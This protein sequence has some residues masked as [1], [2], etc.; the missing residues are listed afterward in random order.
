MTDQLPH[1]DYVAQ[2]ALDGRMM[3]GAAGCVF[4]FGRMEHGVLVTE[5]GWE[6]NADGARSLT[7]FAQKSVARGRRPRDR[8]PWR[9]P[10]GR[11]SEETFKRIGERNP[12]LPFVMICPRGHR[13]LIDL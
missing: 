10:P 2:I 3:C 12:L 4:W 5:D 1:Y 6:T 8:R 11:P 13:N 7:S 9:L